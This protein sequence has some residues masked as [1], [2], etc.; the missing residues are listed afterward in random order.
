M[1][2]LLGIGEICK[3]YGPSMDRTDLRSDGSG[4]DR[5]DL[6]GI[7]TVWIGLI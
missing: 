2:D 5:T 1:M 3:E 4:K 6:S 7:W